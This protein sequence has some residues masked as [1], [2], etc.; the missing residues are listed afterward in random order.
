MDKFKELEEPRLVNVKS[1]RVV[2]VG[3]THGDLD[4]SQRVID[5]FLD[6]STTLVFLGDYVDRGEDSRGN[7]D[8][9]L[10][11]KIKNPNHIYLL[12]GNHEGYPWMKFTPVDFWSGLDKAEFKFYKEIFQQFPLVATFN[13]V[14]A[15]HGALPDLESLKQV[16]QIELGD[17]DWRRITWGD[18]SQR[19]GLEIRP[20]FDRDYFERKMDDFDK[21]FLIR[22]HQPDSPRKMFNDR[23]YT[24][25]TSS[26]Y[27]DQKTV[28]VVS[29][30]ITIKQLC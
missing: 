2:L 9:L 30:K 27:G 4:V 13:D 21:K 3:D 24:I 1:R 26:A 6:S 10:E 11:Q 16:N 19:R 12:Q 8:F 18:F 7:I 23:C 17:D 15:L 22:S 28:A 25:F 29:N 20:T 14:I 5:E